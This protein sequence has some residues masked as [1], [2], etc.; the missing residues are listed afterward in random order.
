MPKKS[1]LDTVR[2]LRHE[3]RKQAELSLASRVLHKNELLARET[4]LFDQLMQSRN[5]A[6]SSQ[7]ADIVSTMEFMDN[8]AAWI[9][10][11]MEQVRA[12]IEKAED[13]IRIARNSL[14]QSY[15]AEKQIEDILQKRHKEHVQ[16][17]MRSIQLVSDEQYL[18]NQ[19]HNSV[20]VCEVES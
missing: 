2:R 11:Q 14:N 7:D 18:M 10:C 12:E 15:K 9:D 19:Y 13:R 3:K 16:K 20:E 5:Q 1:P 4:D 6:V 17:V 8:F